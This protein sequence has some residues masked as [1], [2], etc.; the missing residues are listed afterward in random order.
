MT[1]YLS[2]DEL[3]ALLGGAGAFDDVVR[4]H[5]IGGLP[6]FF[7]NKEDLYG[8]F[9]AH[10]AHGLGVDP[11][12]VCLVGSGRTGFA[13]SPDAFPRPFH[14]G[15]DIDV[16][17]VSPALFDT[18]WLALVSWGHPRRFGLPAGE[19]KWMLQRQ[20]EV[21]WGWLRPDQLRFTGLKFPKD[22][23]PLRSV[24][25][26]WFGTFQ[27]VGVTFPGTDL[28][29]REVSGRLYRSWDHLVRYQ[30]EGLR[31]LRNELNRRS[32]SEAR[33]ELQ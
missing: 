22:L 10:F 30:A 33:S 29:T 19:R 5:I 7:R 26:A 16:A 13:M 12:D 8:S 32:T 28:A 15:S 9:C 6:W 18:A 31:R 25:S 3:T 21:F 20:T 14:A 17:I 2:A 11:G 4:D 1:T 23:F 27:S 24:K